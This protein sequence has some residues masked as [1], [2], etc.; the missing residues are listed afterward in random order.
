MWLRNSIYFWK[1]VK[2]WEEGEKTAQMRLKKAVEGNSL[3]NK[4]V[5][6]SRYDK[7]QDWAA[8]MLKYML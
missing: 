7:D 1:L 6:G 2:I 8:E 4:N 3:K 5:L